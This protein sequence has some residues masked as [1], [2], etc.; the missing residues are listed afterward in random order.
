MAY[1]LTGLTG[2]LGNAIGELLNQQETLY[3]LVRGGR[4]RANGSEK[5]NGLPVEQ[6]F[7]GDITKE[8]C[9][10]NLADLD[11]LKEKKIKK[12]IHSAASIKFDDRLADE[13]WHTNHQGTLNV[14]AL[15]K[16]LHVEEIWYVSTAYSNTRRNP[17]EKSKAQAE[18]EIMSSGLKY[19]IIA[20]SVII[21]DSL[22]GETTSFDGMY[23]YFVGF[24]RISKQI[25]P[26]T[27]TGK[28][29]LPVCIDCSFAS[30][31]NLVPM[32]WVARMLVKLVG[33][34]V[35]GKKYFLVHNEPPLV[36]KIMDIG[37]RHFGIEGVIFRENGEPVPEPK[38]P[39]VKLV[40]K[41]ISRNL[42]TYKRYVTEESIDCNDDL[43]HVLGESY[44]K[45]P[46]VS[47]EM[48][49]TMLDYAATVNFGKPI[50]KGE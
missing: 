33:A 26:D 38:D 20:P 46:L 1:L 8:N 42:E 27:E 32:D 34:G 17:Y 39:T 47:G 50:K 9:G 28:I 25:P 11:F 4:E 49:C 5:L 15:A 22:T 12:L 7:K 31:I 19:G 35:C 48:V 44:E 45:P 14:I 24:Y 21:G 36:Q 3:C 30:T 41:M 40:Q 2:G 6:I 10:L 29:I 18:V 37:I 16:K 43:K 23:G 13:T